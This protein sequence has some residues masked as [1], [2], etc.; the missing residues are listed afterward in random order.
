MPDLSNPYT[1][2]LV[3]IFMFL[4]VVGRYLLVAGLFQLWFYH[5]KKE[6]WQSRVLAFKKAGNRQFYR[7]LQWSVFTSFIFALAGSVTAILWQRGYTRL[8]TD[9]AQYSLWYL[10]VSLLFSMFIHDTY[11]YWL[12]RWMHRPKVFRLMHKVHHDSRITSAWTA[13]SFHP[14][15]GILQ[16][17]ILPLI[18][19]TLPLH[20]FVLLAQLTLMTFSSV[21]NH[22]EI[23]IYP[24]GF[25]RHFI[26]GWLIGATH[27]SLH[28]KEYRYNFGLYFNFWDKWKKTESPRFPIVFK[29]KTKA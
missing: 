10:P 19:I 14:L 26:G 28:H 25:D 11:Y 17:I 22:L 4:V 16:A 18:I 15:E 8:Y 1:F 6:K 20:Y 2:L 21:I 27:H 5:I 23:E 29:I 24:A 12:H 13:F 9:P 3:T 7:E